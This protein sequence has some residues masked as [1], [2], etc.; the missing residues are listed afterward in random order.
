[1]LKKNLLSELFTDYSEYLSTQCTTSELQECLQTYHSGYSEDARK[2]IRIAGLSVFKP[3]NYQYVRSFGQSREFTLNLGVHSTLIGMV[4]FILSKIGSVPIG[5]KSFLTV[6]ITPEDISKKIKTL[7]LKKPLEA[8][9]SLREKGI[10]GL[11]PT[12]ALV[13]W[14]GLTYSNSEMNL[15]NVFIIKEPVGQMPSSLYHEYTFSLKT[16]MSIAEKISDAGESPLKS[17]EHLLKEALKYNAKERAFAITIAKKIFQ[18]ISGSARPEEL[19]YLA[20][21]EALVGSKSSKVSYIRR[22]APIVALSIQQ[23]MNVYQ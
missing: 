21:R 14:L 17:Y 7:Q 11:N 12:E 15:I 18:V 19:T 16:V 23:S 6:L 2:T 22:I 4:G 5:K 1:M 10:P 8:M 13:L 9:R 3:E 20:S